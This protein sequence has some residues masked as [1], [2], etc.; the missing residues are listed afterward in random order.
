NAAM[1]HI[2]DWIHGTPAG[3]WVTMGIPS[4]GSYGIPEGVIFGY[5]VTCSGGQVRI[6]QG[7]DLS[8][9]SRA[10]I[11]AT[12]DELLEERSAVTGLLG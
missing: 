6:V 5:P 1:N 4:D 3:D 10:R 7:L 2:R 12:H 9:F 11:K 8:D